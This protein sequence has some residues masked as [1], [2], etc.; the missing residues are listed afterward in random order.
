MSAD[1]KVAWLYKHIGPDVAF[2]Q[3]FASTAFI[4]C[5]KNSK[6]INRWNY[7]VSN[8][9]VEKFP[10]KNVLHSRKAGIPRMQR[11]RR[12]ARNLELNLKQM[13]KVCNKT[14]EIACSTRPWRK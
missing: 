14:A 13:G 1:R 2:Q 6:S 9:V 8:R 12:L 4:N 10:L 5:E 3:I 11:G 7:A